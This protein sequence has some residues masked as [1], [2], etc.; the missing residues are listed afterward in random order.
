MLRLYKEYLLLLICCGTMFLNSCF[1]S[2]TD[3]VL[4]YEEKIV[5]S[6]ILSAGDTI[7]N[8][9][10]SRTLPPL[11]T[12]LLEKVYLPDA[13]AFI[14]VDGITHP[15]KLQEYLPKDSLTVK[16]GNIR[17]LYCVPNL[18]A[19]AG[20]KYALRVEWYGKIAEAETFV[21]EKPIVSSAK[22]IPLEENKLQIFINGALLY[23]STFAALEVTLPARPQEAYGIFR[24]FV[25]RENDTNWQDYIFFYTERIPTQMF[26]ARNANAG[27][28]QF[29]ERANYAFPLSPQSVM[30]GGLVA[31]DGAMYD[32]LQTQENNSN[33]PI[34]SSLIYGSNT[35]NPQWNV[36]KDGIGVFVGRSEPL[37][38]RVK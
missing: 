19:T 37:F 18:V 25:T 16:Y 10:I 7:K 34:S 11:D 1:S 35:N 28:I 17:S 8:I 27:V 30:I 9:H 21:P 38:L 6:G 36:R 5:V 32:Y 22:V 2:V 20:K 15:M 24:I 13:K 23:R 4:P 12:F 26:H 3:A 33:S 31:Y 14:T 29:A